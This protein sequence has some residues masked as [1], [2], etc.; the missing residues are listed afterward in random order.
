MEA[1]R[2]TSRPLIDTDEIQEYDLEHVEK[3]FM[4]LDE[5]REDRLCE[6]TGTNELE[7]VETLELKLDTTKQSLSQLGFLVPNLKTLQL[8]NSVLSSFRDFGTS[9]RGLKVLYLEQSQVYD[10]DGIGVLLGLEELYLGF[11]NIDDLTPLAMHDNLKKIDL[12]SNS[13]A[14]INQ[15]DQ[16]GTCFALEWLCLEN[17]PI[18]TI[19]RYRHIVCHC[20]PQLQ[21]LDF[22]MINDGD[23]IPIDSNVIESAL[24]SS[25]AIPQMKTLARP[26]SS[27][28][29]ERPQS[30]RGDRETTNKETEKTSTNEILS[31]SSNLTHGSDVVFAG[32][33]ASSM[34]KRRSKSDIDKT[35]EDLMNWSRTLENDL[36]Q[37][38][39]NSNEKEI[40]NP[41]STRPKTIEHRIRKSKSSSNIKPHPPKQPKQPKPPQRC[42]DQIF[43]I[44]QQFQ[45]DL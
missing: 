14:D 36:K 30:R 11:N 45:D 17:N 34:R 38:Q 19:V 27:V 10:L 13:I 29:I 12:Q 15:I 42:E 2:I 4:H 43:T 41:P 25:K 37:L 16:L 39:E 32:N 40:R 5:L 31:S 6:I 33:L 20:I 23:K 28:L 8:N 26:R 22:K 21:S 1:F 44:L 9:L 24:K 3:V 35:L 7:T 18:C